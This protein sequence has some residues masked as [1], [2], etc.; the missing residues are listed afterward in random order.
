MGCQHSGVQSHMHNPRRREYPR[1]QP[2]HVE[3][4]V[5]EREEATYPEHVLVASGERT[6]SAGAGLTVIL[7]GCGE[8]KARDGTA[9]LPSATKERKH[10]RNDKSKLREKSK[11]KRLVSP[12]GK[13]KYARARDCASSERDCALA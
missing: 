11:R 10:K 8:K 2:K 9:N 1:R 7:L 13:S 6:P 3:D 5:L 4:S 12:R